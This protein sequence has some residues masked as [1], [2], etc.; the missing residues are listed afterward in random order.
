MRNS[1]IIFFIAF[2]L[3]ACSDKNKL[4]KG[5]MPVN[6]MKEVMWDMIRAGE[7]L[8]GVAFVKDSSNRAAVSQQWFNKIYEIHKISKEQFDKSYAFYNE[9]P[10]LMKEVLDSLSK[11]QVNTYP[12]AINT[13]P[14]TPAFDSLA[15]KNIRLHQPDSIRK[16]FIDS[17]RRKKMIKKRNINPQ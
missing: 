8:N 3:F 5:V 7:F 6:Q 10:L 4:P 14:P 13:N 15:K 11:K 2:F 1:F 12:T 16:V 9:H 17:M